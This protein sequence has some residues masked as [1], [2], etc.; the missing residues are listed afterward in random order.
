MES[1]NAEEALEEGMEELRQ[2]ET[3]LEREEEPLL[4]VAEQAQMLKSL[5]ER[6]LATQQ[7]LPSV[8][9]AMVRAEKDVHEGILRER[10]KRNRQESNEIE[11]ALKKWC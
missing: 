10:L 8:A 11:R 5:S 7:N 3:V 9:E 2:R 6:L 1:E 4:S